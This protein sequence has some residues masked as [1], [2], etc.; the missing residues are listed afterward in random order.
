MKSQITITLLALVILGYICLRVPNYFLDG[1]DYEIISSKRSPD[2]RF[3]IIEFQSN[4]EEAH[5]PYGQ[6]LVLSWKPVNKPKQGH[7]IFAGYCKKLT[8]SW[9]S[10]QKIAI[11]CESTEKNNVRSRSTKAYGIE[12][13]YQ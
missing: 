9:V 12:I 2:D 4:G 1:A 7:I 13:E 3:L 10:E 5:A 6:H 8:Y 11:A